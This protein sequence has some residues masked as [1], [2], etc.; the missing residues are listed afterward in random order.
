MC[1]RPVPA[2]NTE[3]GVRAVVKDRPIDP[4]QVRKY[5]EG[6]FGEQLKAVRGAM[7]QL[8]RSFRPKELAEGAYG[9]Y[10]KFRPKIAPGKRGWGQKG[11]LDTDLIRTLAK[12]N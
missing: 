2:K 11:E 8:A 5:L 9:L 12:K 7:L 3:E 4:A 1:G 10:E 6:K